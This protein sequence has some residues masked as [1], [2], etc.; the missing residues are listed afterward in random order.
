MCPQCAG[1]LHEM[2]T[3]IRIEIRVIPA[4]VKVI[5]HVQH[6]YA[7]RACERTRIRTPVVRALMPKPP[8]PGSYASPS[9]IAS[10]IHNKYVQG[11]PL[12]RQEQ[13]FS[14]LGVGLSRQTLANWTLKATERHLVPIY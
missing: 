5:E 10:V 11:I 2:S 9:A 12:Y 14:R 4:Q 7:C 8:I 1:R 6:V 3:S 13:E